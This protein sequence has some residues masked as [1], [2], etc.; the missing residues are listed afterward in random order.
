MQHERVEREERPLLHY[1]A[2][3]IRVAVSDP[4]L[5]LGPHSGKAVIAPAPPDGVGVPQ[6]ERRGV[7]TGRE[8]HVEVRFLGTQVPDQVDHRIE[9]TVELATRDDARGVAGPVELE[10]VHAVPADHRETGFAEALVVIGA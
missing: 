7:G 9:V 5:P 1:A 3:G 2:V 6:E 10:L 4:L 8:V